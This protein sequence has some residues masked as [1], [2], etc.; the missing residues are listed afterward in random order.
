L[1][2]V[3]G[4]LYFAAAIYWATDGIIGDMTQKLVAIVRD[5]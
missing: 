5:G 1:I 4:K 2:Y 3:S